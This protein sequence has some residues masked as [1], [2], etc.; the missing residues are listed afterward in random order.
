[1]GSFVLL[2]VVLLNKEKG[3]KQKITRTKIMDKSWSHK[4]IICEEDL[5]LLVLEGDKE[6]NLTSFKV[7]IFLWRFIY[8]KSKINYSI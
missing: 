3:Q 1:M 6:F 8:S 4:P 2:D 5:S 7:R